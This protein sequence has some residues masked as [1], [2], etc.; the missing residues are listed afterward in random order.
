MDSSALIGLA[1]AGALAAVLTRQPPVPAGP[2]ADTTSITAGEIYEQIDQKIHPHIYNAMID[3]NRNGF[4]IDMFQREMQ[5]NAVA[6]PD[7]SMESLSAF[8]DSVRGLV[9][10]KARIVRGVHK[11]AL[12]R[13]ESTR[14]LQAS[15]RS[16]VLPGA[17]SDVTQDSRY[18][19]PGISRFH[20]H[21]HVP[22]P[23][24]E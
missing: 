1:A 8:A 22:A 19:T 20:G 21:V 10:E 6:P 11:A 23:Y 18:Y 15:E 12:R 17:L 24:Y 13:R 9:A 2:V 4:Q 14:T 5:L 3:T 16:K 7:G